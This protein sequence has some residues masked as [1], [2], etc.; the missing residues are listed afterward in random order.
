[1]QHC[2]RSRLIT[3][4]CSCILLHTHFAHF[5][6]LKRITLA[7]VWAVSHFHAYLYRHAVTVYN[8]HSVSQLCWELQVPTASMLNGGLVF[9]SRIQKIDMSTYQEERTMSLMHFQVIPKWVYKM[10]RVMSYKR[11]QCVLYVYGYS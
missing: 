7:V 4:Y 9:D 1:M 11:L 8:D 5:E 6:I 2:L 3:F 10:N